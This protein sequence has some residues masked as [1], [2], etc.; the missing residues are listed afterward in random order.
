MMKGNCSDTSASGKT[1]AYLGCMRLAAHWT[2]SHPV[3]QFWFIWSDKLGL[4]E[5]SQDYITLRLTMKLVSHR[6]FDSKQQALA[7][8]ILRAIRSELEG[9][10]APP[11]LVEQLTGNIGFAVTAI[12]DD[13]R[14]IEVEGKA[15]SPVVTFLINNDELEFGGGNS[16]MHEY[17]YKLLPTVF[18][19]ASAREGTHES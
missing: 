11:E 4:P 12:L 15:L 8:A 6:S 17:V 19:D 9:V 10:D 2:D 3:A 7:E 14:S 5:Y 16:W 18:A 13:S 1:I